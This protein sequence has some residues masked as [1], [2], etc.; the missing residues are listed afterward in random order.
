MTVH[1]QEG[2]AC[3]WLLGKVEGWMKGYKLHICRD[4][5]EEDSVDRVSYL[6]SIL[7]NVVFEAFLLRHKNTVRACK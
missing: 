7:L 4:E 3:F 5:A 1:C 6:I 2:E